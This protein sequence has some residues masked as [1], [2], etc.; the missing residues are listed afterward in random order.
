MFALRISITGL[1]AFLIWFIS[2]PVHGMLD[3]PS[4]MGVPHDV[5]GVPPVTGGPLVQESGVPQRTGG[6][7]AREAMSYLSLAGQGRAGSQVADER[8]NWSLGRYEET[9]IDLQVRVKGGHVTHQRRLSAGHE[10]QFN[11]AWQ[12]LDLGHRSDHEEGDAPDVIRRGDLNYERVDSSDTYIYDQRR[13]ITK[14]ENGYLWRD[15]RGNEI[16]Y[17]EDGHIRAYSN[18]NDVKVNFELDDDRKISR[19]LDHHGSAVMNFAY[20]SEG[21]LIEVTDRVG[22]SVKYV[23]SE[24]EDHEGDLL[25]VEDILGGGWEYEYRRYYDHGKP[26]RLVIARKGPNAGLDLNLTYE[27]GEDP[28]ATL[29]GS[30]QVCVRRSATNWRWDDDLEGWNM[31]VECEAFRPVGSGAPVLAQMYNK[32]FEYYYDEGFEEYRIVERNSVGG[33]D[34]RD[35]SMD[36]RLTNHQRGMEQRVETLST[37]YQQGQVRVREDSEGNQTITEIDQWDNPIR[38]EHP[39]G[40]VER[41]EWHSRYRVPTRYT[42]ADGTVTEYEYDSRGNRIRHIEAVGTAQERV[43]EHSYDSHGNRISTRR[44]GADGSGTIET[45]FEYDNFG[46]LTAQIDGEGHR[47][48]FHD[49]DVL[50]NPGKVIDARGN[51]WVYAYDAVGNLESVESP[52]GRVV[53]YDY[54]EGGVLLSVK[55]PTGGKVSFDYNAQGRVTAVNNARGERTRFNYDAA[56]RMTE[57]IDPLGNVTSFGYTMAGQRNSVTT[58]DGETTKYRYDGSGGL[59]SGIESAGYSESYSYDRRLRRAGIARKGEDAAERQTEYARDISGRVQEKSDPMQRSHEFEYDALGRRIGLIDPAGQRT[60]LRYDPHGNLREIINPR[61]I[62][63]RRYEYDQNRRL[64]QELMPD[65]EAIEYHYDPNGNLTRITH[66]EG[67]T[68]VYR[69]DADNFLAEVYYFDHVSEIEEESNATR[70][71][72]FDYDKAGRLAGYADQ[73]SSAQYEYDEVGRLTGS[74][75]DY[76]DFKLSYSYTYYDNGRVETF[77]NPDG[78]TYQYA[79]TPGGKLREIVIPGEGVYRINEYDGPAPTDITLPGGTRKEIAYDGYGQMRELKAEDPAGDALLSWSYEHDVVGN[80]T[81]RSRDSEATHYGYDLL[82]RLTDIDGPTESNEYVYDPVGNR[83]SESKF[84]SE[85]GTPHDWEYDDRDRL[86]RR[87]HIEYEYDANGNRVVKR[88]T[89]SGSET[90]YQYDANNRLVR[91]EEGGSTMAKYTYDPFGQ[92]VSKEVGNEKTYFLYSPEGLIAE[93]DGGGDVHTSYGWEPRGLWGT[94]P[95]FIK[96]YS[97]YGYYLND[98]LGAPWMVVS[99][100]GRVLWEGEYDAFGAVKVMRED[101]VNNLRLPGQYADWETGLLYNFN[102]YYDSGEGR[103]LRTDSIGLLGG[104]NGSIYVSNRPLVF[105]D[106]LGLVGNFVGD[107]WVRDRYRNTGDVEDNTAICGYYDGVHEMHGCEYHGGAGEVCRGERTLVNI[108]S[109]LCRID[110]RQKNCIRSCLVEEDINARWN[111]PE[112]RTHP[113]KD[114]NDCEDDFLGDCVRRGCIDEYHNECFS[115]CG[116]GFSESTRCYGGN[117]PGGWALMENDGI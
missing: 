5:T 43:T 114:S 107:D 54:G 22:R 115:G 86:I 9:S 104:I 4:G 72:T 26:I 70:H 71:I 44:H 117:L 66:P 36:G 15:R 32:S 10:W 1:V 85:E 14:K 89:Q 109:S 27:G 53:E 16:H 60:D 56:D 97:Q 112:C 76:G 101:F 18:S 77:T 106:K 20:D 52:K 113:G 91:V 79:W 28:S 95:L 47:V 81:E 46:N 80:I 69:Y 25:E 87:G 21:R 116:V 50:G 8:V 13:R 41:Y 88:D 62:P 49:H 30:G 61:Q 84:K 90:R 92:R 48:E 6:D 42:S 59:L 64:V 33:L 110:N 93:S 96:Q 78:T 51:A 67:N 73:Y 111:R 40:A 37:S 39:D 7:S 57:I 68:L 23:W 102:R 82:D 34:I 74:E 24:V 29:S 3:E 99:S 12:P 98:H 19:I 17:D 35:Y 45:S 55:D 105:S 2:A 108:W 63:V 100:S 83:L 58:P 38:I 65:G 103:Y 75:V 31:D 11:P 94:N